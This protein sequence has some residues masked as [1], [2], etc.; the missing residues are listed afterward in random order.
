MAQSTVS[1][2]LGGTLDEI[3]QR[4]GQPTWTDTGLIGYN[5]VDI[6][7]IPTIL[8]VYYDSA[9]AVTKISLV[10]TG[11]PPELSSPEAVK[12]AVLEVTPLDSNCV[13]EATTSGFGS[14]VYACESKSLLPLYSP[15]YLEQLGV[16]GTAGSFSYAVDPTADE[17]YEVVVQL[18]TDTIVVPPTAVPTQEPTMDMQYP[19]VADIRELAIGRG[20]QTGDNLSF[21]GTVLT[22]FVA[23]PGMG[24]TLGTNSELVASTALQV[25]VAAPDGSIATIVVGYN[26]DTTGVFEG[27]WI[28]VYG[29]LRG[30]ECGTNLLGGQI[31]QPLIEAVEVAS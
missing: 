25:D 20:Y 28:T 17:Y 3:E 15:Q 30:T 13:S 12:A 14:E 19:P 7:G 29:V 9:N 8:V 5:E 6:N 31:C 4:F 18:G 23:D 27:S 11:Q 21:S 26:G 2:R 10:Y 22:I 16:K 1:G 24:F